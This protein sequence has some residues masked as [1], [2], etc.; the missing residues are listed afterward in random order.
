MSDAVATTAGQSE[1][2]EAPRYRSPFVILA[3]YVARAQIGERAALSRMNPKDPMPH[4]LAALSRA[5]VAARLTPERW[6]TASWHHWAVIAQGMALTGHAADA[7]GEQLARSGV[8][9]SRVTKLLT[10][11]GDAFT[12]VLP[13]ILRYMAS[14]GVAPNWTELGRLVLYEAA[15]KTEELRLRIA[16]RYFSAKARAEAASKN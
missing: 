14:K 15:P 12:Q 6:S 16:G 11:R 13:R 3:H 9:E 4:Q 10:S 7:L 2:T 1:S 5:A 8:A